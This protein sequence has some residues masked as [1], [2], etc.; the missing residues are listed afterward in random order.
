MKTRAT[1][2]HEQKM[3]K[4]AQLERVISDAQSELM[5]LSNEAGQDPPTGG[6]IVPE[7]QSQTQARPQS[8]LQHSSY[9]NGCDSRDEDF[10]QRAVDR[11]LVTYETAREMY[12]IFQKDGAMY[13]PFDIIEKPDLEANCRVWPMA[14]VTM[15]YAALANTHQNDT[16]EAFGRFIRTEVAHRMYVDFD[17]SIDLIYSVF[18]YMVFTFSSGDTEDSTV[19]SFFLILSGVITMDIANKDDIK[20]MHRAEPSSKRWKEARRNIQLFLA[21]HTGVTSMTASW[22]RQ[23]LV[24]MTPVPS[25]YLDALSTTRNPDDLIV[26]YHIRANLLINSALE[27]ITGPANLQPTAIKRSV[28]YYMNQ[29]K[30]LRHLAEDGLGDQFFHGRY[31]YLLYDTL[32]MLE[33]ALSENAVNQLIGHG[34]SSNDDWGFYILPFMHGAHHLV[35]SF[36]EVVQHG[37]IF[38]RFFYIRALYALVSLLRC[39]VIMWSFGQENTAELGLQDSLTKIQQAWSKCTQKS[40]T[41]QSLHPLL[42]KVEGW[43]QILDSKKADGD[44]PSREAVQKS[45]RLIQDL[46]R[47]LDQKAEPPPPPPSSAYDDQN[48]VEQIL[49]ELFSEI[50]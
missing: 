21:Y 44:R 46:V 50:I 14:T 28:D 40:T 29:L 24:N 18:M 32:I 42:L 11:G 27:A 41:A 48:Q 15:V 12:G 35:D 37:T 5:Q 8:R 34:C 4:M 3:E 2:T 22:Y 13:F 7:L 31:R 20:A 6:L 33:M 47:S 49:Q 16:I 30:D 10:L 23:R 39:N 43:V 36:V 9:R 1:S 17:F 19:V 38:P 45:S 25:Q 26:V